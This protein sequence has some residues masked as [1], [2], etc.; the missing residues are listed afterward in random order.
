MGLVTFLGVKANCTG[1]KR[2]ENNPDG[3]AGLNR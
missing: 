1:K 3:P 2:L